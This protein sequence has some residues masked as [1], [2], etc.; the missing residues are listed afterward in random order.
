MFDLSASVKPDAAITPEDLAPHMGAVEKGDIV[1]LHTGYG[2]K[3]GFSPDYLLKYPYVGG[4]AGE[5]LAAAGVKGVGTDALSIGCF[6]SPEKA[7]PGHVV[8]LSNNI[9][10]IEEL[11][12]PAALLDGKKRYITA[13]PLFM[14]GCSGAPVR[15]VMLE[16]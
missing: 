4:P 7:G 8:L 2:Q 15:A 10:L 11:C 5:M 1:L 16:F 14:Q 3:R 6:G 12:I 13:F 9:F